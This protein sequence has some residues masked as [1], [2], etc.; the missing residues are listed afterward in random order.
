M[1][2]AILDEIYQK[3]CIEYKEMSVSEFCRQW[4][5]VERSYMAVLTAKQ[6]NPSVKVM[7]TCG[8]RVRE[9]GETLALSNYPAVAAR[10]ERLQQLAEECAKRVW[11]AVE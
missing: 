1:T 9:L 4:L 2:G 3:L 10:G 6:R 5:G 8:K 11:D 7:V